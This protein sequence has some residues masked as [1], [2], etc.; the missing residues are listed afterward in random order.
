MNFEEFELT[1]RTPVRVRYADTDKMGVVY[2]VNYFIFFE[3]SRA[4]LMRH[5]GLPYI[6]FEKEGYILPVIETHANFLNSAYYDDLLQVEAKLFVK[7][8]PVVRFEY[9]VFREDTI[10]TKGYTVHSFISAET[11]KA[12]KP[13]QFYFTSI[14]ANK[15]E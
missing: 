3:M 2:N 7:Y 15:P 14:L 1:H 4:E 10:I 5:Y 12:V 13:P 11:R 9:T 6:Q 8:K